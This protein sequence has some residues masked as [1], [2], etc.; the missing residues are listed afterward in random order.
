MRKAVYALG[1]MLMLT[2]GFLAFRK[3]GNSL[4]VIK[5]DGG[6]VSG[7]LSGSGDVYAFSQN[8]AGRPNRIPA[9]DL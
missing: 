4:E 3:T 8:A 6:Q 7:V 9:A 1:F 5:T 2:I